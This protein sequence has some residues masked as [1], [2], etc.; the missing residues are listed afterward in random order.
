[1]N[2]LFF[3]DSIVQG[4]WD[5]KGGW[6][7]RIR[8]DIYSQHLEESMPFEHY[9][10]VFLRGVS[11]DTSGD[12]K[13]RI[14][15]EVKDAAKSSSSEVTVVFS[16][17]INDCSISNEEYEV[18]KE[19]YRE[20][21]REIIDKSK[22]YADRIIAV[23]LTPVDEERLKEE[24]SAAKHTNS[25]VRNY[26]EILREVCSDKEVKFVPLFDELQDD[27]G[28]NKKLF[29]GIHPNS[30]GHKQIYETV[31]KPIISEI[32]IQEGE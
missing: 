18:S 28:W 19:E 15:K 5:E 27:G 24:K 31:K 10:M 6:A 11:G 4:M 22:N 9:N 21:L 12:L 16:I 29:D 30:K 26:N 8:Q 17:G 3:G 23:G 32:N 14:L 1:M 2:L 13:N 7:S 25:E 20:N